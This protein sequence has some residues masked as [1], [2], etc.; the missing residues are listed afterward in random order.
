M[1]SWKN[2]YIKQHFDDGRKR[3]SLRPIYQSA[4]A[5]LQIG[6]GQFTNRPRPIFRLAATDS[7]T[8]RVHLVNN[9]VKTI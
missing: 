6:R 4:A 1:G 9:F 2:P 8:L 3:G 5:N 7:E